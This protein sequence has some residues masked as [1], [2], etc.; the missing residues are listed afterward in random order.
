MATPYTSASDNI[1]Y[2]WVRD[3]AD[4]GTTNTADTTIWHNW[5]NGGGTADTT[6]T[7][8]NIIY[9]NSAVWRSWHSSAPRHTVVLEHSYMP[10][11]PKRSQ[12][13]E[14]AIKTQRK[15][16]RLWSDIRIME[17]HRRKE[18]AELNALNLLED[19]ISDP[20]TLDHYKETN[21]L[22]VKG[23]QFDY[24]IQKGRGVYRVEKEKV[25]DLC[26]HLKQRSKFPA[27]DNVVSLKLMIEGNEKLFLKTANNHGE[28]HSEHTKNKVLEMVN[29]HNRRVA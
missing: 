26:I 27:T 1:F 5:H 2:H 8:T 14:R 4:N 29:E 9:T 6:T 19:L 28:I 25:V 7:Y 23:Q 18:L 21:N 12:E 15:I 16:N 3:S 24:V 22:I 13:E 11:I 20:V 10:V 17:E